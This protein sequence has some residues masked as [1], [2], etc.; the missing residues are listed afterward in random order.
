MSDAPQLS[1]ADAKI[2]LRVP[3]EFGTCPYMSRPKKCNRVEYFDT[4]KR[5]TDAARGKARSF[6]HPEEAVK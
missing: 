3:T 2:S 1:C 5:I 4:Q 6:K